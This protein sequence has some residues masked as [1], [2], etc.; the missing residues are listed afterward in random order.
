VDVVE[1][2]IGTSGGSPSKGKLFRR[3]FPLLLP[4]WIFLVLYPNPLNLVTSLKRVAS[5]QIDA[6]AVASLSQDVPDDPAAIES[7]VLQRIPYSYDWETYGMPWYCPSVKEAL[8][9]GKGDCK[10]RALVL[11]SLLEAKGIPY[12]IS[13]SPVH[14]WVQYEGK[15]ESGLEN[16]E[17][18]FYQQ[19]PETGERSLRLPQISIGEAASMFWEG[20]WGPMPGVR[21]AL[22]LCGLVGLVGVRFSLSKRGNRFL[23]GVQ[24]LP[25]AGLSLFGW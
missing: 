17:V 16:D 13:F 25:K 5:P 6:V 18:K 24:R 14:M 20:F 3:L 10:A 19:D 23:C 7:A 21:K 12:G 1:R 8:E 22:L 15:A 4:L 11:A 9:K 2:S